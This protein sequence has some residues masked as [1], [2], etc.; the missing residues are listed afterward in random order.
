V[1]CNLT[2]AMFGRAAA[3][4]CINLCTAQVWIAGLCTCIGRCEGR[5]GTG[6][7]VFGVFVS[8][9]GLARNS[10]RPSSALELQYLM[11]RYRNFDLHLHTLPPRTQTR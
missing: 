1:S 2:H 3:V 6:K 5:N 4:R 7:G 9:D 8:P 10:R 11:C